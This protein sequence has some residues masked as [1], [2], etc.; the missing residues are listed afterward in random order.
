MGD[1]RVALPLMHLTRWSLALL[2][3]FIRSC[4]CLPLLD[5]TTRRALVRDGF[6]IAESPCPSAADAL[7]LFQAAV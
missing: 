5:A 6:G 1:V 3:P 2:P 7:Q 4:P